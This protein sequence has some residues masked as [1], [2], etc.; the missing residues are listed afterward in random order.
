MAA[1]GLILVIEEG[2]GRIVAARFA[3]LRRADY[4]FEQLTDYFQLGCVEE[5]IPLTSIA[6]TFVIRLKQV[7]QTPK[8]QADQDI[9]LPLFPSSQL[10]P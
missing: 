1:R 9:T 4:E 2:S 6:K 10:L 8:I 3:P 7:H 5:T